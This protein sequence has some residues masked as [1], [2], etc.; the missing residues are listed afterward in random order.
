[1]DF[2]NGLID[3]IAEKFTNFFVAMYSRLRAKDTTAIAP[4]VSAI[5][6]VIKH[7]LEALA[8]SINLAQSGFNAANHLVDGVLATLRRMDLAAAHKAVGQFH[9]YWRII[10]DSLMWGE[11]QNQYRDAYGF[12]KNVADIIATI[13]DAGTA[14]FKTIVSAIDLLVNLIISRV[15]QHY[16]NSALRL[17]QIW[18][19]KFEP[20]IRALGVDQLM[21]SEIDED[22]WDSDGYVRQTRGRSNAVDPVGDQYSSF[23]VRHSAVAREEYRENMRSRDVTDLE[24]AEKL[25]LKGMNRESAKI[26][27][28]LVE[29]N[30]D[31]IRS[32]NPH[33]YSLVDFMNDKEGCFTIYL[34]HMCSASPIITACIVNSGVMSDPKTV[35]TARGYV[36]ES[37]EER[38]MEYMRLAGIT[39][40]NVYAKS[41]FQFAPAPTIASFGAVS[42]KWKGWVAGAQLNTNPNMLTFTS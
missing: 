15:Q 33:L 41:N 9:E 11:K 34:N 8:K 16:I 32:F 3:Y 37:N 31:L 25:R 23:R 29:R 28:D 10:D 1:M 30:A 35:T 13:F 12:I 4:I 40:R 2:I 22:P 18:V 20:E 5:C 21:A 27:S 39:A 36:D 24:R 42:E 6:S 38:A 14:L 7:F 17:A 26:V 19:S